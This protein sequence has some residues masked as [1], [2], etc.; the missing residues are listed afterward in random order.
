MMPAA[1]GYLLVAIVCE[2]IGTSLLKASDGFTRLL[3]SVVTVL[4]YGV[5][6]YCL[7]ICLRTMPIG[8]AYAVWCGLGI[9][10]V[11]LVGVLWFKQPLDWPAILGIVLIFA[12]V[13]VINLFSASAPH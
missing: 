11:A 1:Y 10:L 7:S 4:S 12:G 2:V 6:F 5:A 9:V 13:L 3:P 8:L